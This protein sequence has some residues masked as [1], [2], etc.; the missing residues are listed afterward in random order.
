M[1]KAKVS[2]LPS[3]A[4]PKVVPWLWANDAWQEAYPALYELLAAGLYEGEQRKPAT[5]SIFVSEG[6]L[7]ACVRDRHTK[8]ALWLTLEGNIDL[9]REIEDAITSSAGEWRAFRSGDENGA[10]F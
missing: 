2:A 3:K 4:G 9:I 6:R 1:A 8:Q 10:T 7:K 5:L